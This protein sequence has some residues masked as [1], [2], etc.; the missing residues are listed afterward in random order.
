MELVEGR[1]LRELLGDGPVPTRRLL[2]LGVQIAEGLAK[3]HAAGIVHRDLKPENV[4][5]SKDGGAKILDFGLAKLL[6]PQP[7]GDDEPPDGGL[8]DAGPGR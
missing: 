4:M 5:V 7:D 8:G 1:T 6:K 3:A 2:D